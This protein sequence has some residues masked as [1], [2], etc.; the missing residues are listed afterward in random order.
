MNGIIVPAYRL[1]ALLGN[2]PLLGGLFTGGKGGGMFALSYRIKGKVADPTISVN[3]L[4]AIIPGILRKPFEGSKGTLDKVEPD[5]EEPSP[6]PDSESDEG[7][8][9]DSEE[10]PLFH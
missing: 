1:N 5:E 9:A 4:T 10:P 8:D 2:I 6:E 7:L 3:A